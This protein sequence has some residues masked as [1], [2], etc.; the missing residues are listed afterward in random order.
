MLKKKNLRSLS[1]PAI[2]KNISFLFFF[3]QKDRLQLKQD[4][5]KSIYVG[6]SESN[7]PLFIFAET[8]K[9]I[10]RGCKL[11]LYDC[12]QICIKKGYLKLRGVT[13]IAV[14]MDMMNWIQILD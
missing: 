2:H 11:Q 1:F 8:I 6:R 14:E 13:I 12:E 4:A 7:A 10:G 3:L 9:D 5:W